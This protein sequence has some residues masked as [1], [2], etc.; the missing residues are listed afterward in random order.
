MIA[1]AKPPQSVPC[2]DVPGEGQR[3]VKTTP[4]CDSTFDCVLGFSC[5]EGAC[6]DRRVPCFVDAE[7]P[8]SHVCHAF[9]ATRFCLRVHQSCEEEF[10]CENLA[11]RCD[12][13]DGD[14]R[15]ECAPTFN[16]NVWPPEACLNSM[17]AP[18]APVCQ[19]TD[20]DARTRCGEYGLCV[21]PEDCVEGFD[22]VGLWP[23][24]RRECVPSGGSCAHVSE[25][26]V[27]QVCASPREGGPPR[28]QGGVEPG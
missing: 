24:G 22:C 8:K 19:L 11:A 15:T 12:D 21:G 17:C 14:G 20:G 16:P 10:D 28:C 5:E 3:C 4:G 7:C 18:Q 23:D 13:V 25:C 2:T 26:P 1:A 27:R 6:V 9:D